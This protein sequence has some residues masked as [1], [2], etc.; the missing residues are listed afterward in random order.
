M[1]APAAHDEPETV[2]LDPEGARLVITVRTRGGVVKLVRDLAVPAASPDACRDLAAAAAVV[3]ATWKLHQTEDLSLL[4]P[5]VYPPPESPSISARNPSTDVTG[6]APV[7]LG[8][9]GPDG[10]WAPFAFLGA[11]I[12]VAA[13]QG[14]AAATVRLDAGKRPRGWPLGLQVALAADTERQLSVE[15]GTSSWWRLTIGAGPALALSPPGDGKSWLGVELV[16]QFFLG[17][18]SVAGHGYALDRTDRALSAGL[19]GLIRVVLT[20]E[21]QPFVEAG[22][23]AWLS[24]QDLVV[25]RPGQSDAYTSL[26]RAEG[27]FLA[28]LRFALA[29]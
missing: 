19:D 27:R 15:E 7:A 22:A 17:M 18:T 20:G 29:P 8:A 4:Q 23:R 9:H 6:S 26:P 5:G 11:S 24:P 21:L 13:N 2:S 25:V 3:I 14:G 1:L 12:G 28:G 10:I 16:G